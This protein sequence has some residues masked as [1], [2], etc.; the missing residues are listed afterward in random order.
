MGESNSSVCV[1]NGNNEHLSCQF[2][3]LL[4]YLSPVF[5]CSIM[6]IILKTKSACHEEKHFQTLLKCNSAWECSLSADTLLKR[7]AALRTTVKCDLCKLTLDGNANSDK[8]ATGC[9]Q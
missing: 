4:N 8:R 1:L 7:P 6:W 9:K 5:L 2:I 3:E